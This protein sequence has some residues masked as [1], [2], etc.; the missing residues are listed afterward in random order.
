MHLFTELSIY[1]SFYVKQSSE[2]PDLALLWRSIFSKQSGPSGAPIR[3]RF[4]RNVC[5]GDA[6]GAGDSERAP[7]EAGTCPTPSVVWGSVRGPDA[8]GPA[9]LRA[10]VVERVSIWSDMCSLY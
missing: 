2:M 3:N 5:I 8:S 10:V 6:A 1:Q 9:P 7:A 4:C